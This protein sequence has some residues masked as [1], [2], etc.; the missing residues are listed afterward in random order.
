MS[1]IAVDI[2]GKIST[3]TLG[4]IIEDLRDLCKKSPKALFKVYGQI[5]NIKYGQGDNGTWTKFIGQFEAVNLLNGN[6]VRSGSLFLPS[7]ITT[8]VEGEV[9]AAKGGEGFQGLAIAY[10]VGVK[11]SD[12]TIGYEYTIRNLLPTDEDKDMLVKMRNQ[13]EATKS[14]PTPKK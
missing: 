13:L 6:V 4:F 10:E 5:V 3:K 8:M 9:T 14:L 2:V 12:L 11:K 1:K 7:I